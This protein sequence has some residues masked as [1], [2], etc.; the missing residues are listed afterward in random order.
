MITRAEQDY[1][2][3]CASEL[4]SIQMQA[5]VL[6]RG[7]P[8]D[9]EKAKSVFFHSLASF[10]QRLGLDNQ[11]ELF[12]LAAATGGPPIHREHEKP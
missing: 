6:A 8:A 2:A 9:P 12:R 7:R 1:F 10:A 5:D 11:A 4:R 3:R